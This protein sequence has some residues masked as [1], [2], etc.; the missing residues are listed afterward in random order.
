MKAILSLEKGIIPATVGVKT[1]NPNSKPSKIVA[2]SQKL[3]HVVDFDAA[4]VK[5]VT[6]T[7]P[8]PA[9]APRRISVNSFGYGGANGHCIIDH[10]N[11]LLLKEFDDLSTDNTCVSV[12]TTSSEDTDAILPQSPHFSDRQGIGSKPRTS[13]RDAATVPAPKASKNLPSSANMETRRLV[14]LVFSAHD[15]SS[16]ASNILAI[17]DICP[18]YS[19]SDLAYTLST[20][21]TRFLY[22][23][24]LIVESS[25][26]TKGFE[27]NKL[28][29]TKSLSTKPSHVAFVFTGMSFHDTSLPL[30]CIGF[31]NGT[32]G[33]VPSGK[34][35]EQSL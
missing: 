25:V 24:F 30:I 9:H 20:R 8:W 10:R 6:E 16:L 5:V 17:R 18:N 31:A 33:K 27:I 19:L 3:T 26:P 21:R 7:T 32:K 28:I 2:K 14:L 13:T 12:S 11:L 35:W 4:G 22:K 29:I 15:H 23:T 1:L 34:T